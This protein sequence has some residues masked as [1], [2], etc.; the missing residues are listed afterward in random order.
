MHEQ[1]EADEN[2]VQYCIQKN[3]KEKYA[4]YLNCFLAEDNKNEACR[5]EVGIN[6]T[7]L[8]SCIAEADKEF[9]I[10][11]KMKDTSKRFPDYDINKKEALAA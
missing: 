6:E 3:E 10:S 5:K 7:L 11:E 1:K 8:S 9:N 4:K 2:T